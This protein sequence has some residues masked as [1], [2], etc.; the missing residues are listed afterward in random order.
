[1]PSPK[2]KCCKAEF[3]LDIDD[4]QEPC[5]VCSKCGREKKQAKSTPP[6]ARPL[7]L[8]EAKRWLRVGSLV[9]S[10]TY[11]ITDALDVEIVT[12][13]IRRGERVILLGR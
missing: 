5:V 9:T 3:G 13:R 12:E 2:S 11:R 1:M 4:E 10:A 6:I 8:S 7:T